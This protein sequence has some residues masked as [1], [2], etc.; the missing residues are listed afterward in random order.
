MSPEPYYVPPLTTTDDT[1]Q[2][3]HTEHTEHTE[4]PDN[5]ARHHELPLF[6]RVRPPLEQ[7]E[8]EPPLILLLH[9]VGSNEED[10]FPVAARMSPNAVVASLRGPLV[11]G[12]HAYAW[13]TVRFT[14]T[15]AEIDAE[16]LEASR[17]RVAE[18]VRAAV[19]RYAA[20]P[21]RVYLVGF[22]Q[23][24]IMSLTLG[25]TEPALVA[26]VVA[27]A[28]RIP[29]EVL[30]GLAGPNA[31]AG[32]PV[33]VAHGQRD[34]II[35]VEEGRK[36]RRILQE[37]RVALAYTEYPGVG[38]NLPPEAWNAALGWLSRQIAAPA[39]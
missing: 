8:G 2:M 25:L 16:E 31:T 13:F 14:P 20:D 15:G 11:R 30:P 27:M 6:A 28:G 22:S 34:E 24:A 17:A 36:A 26:G 3:D 33:Y 35:G 7:S 18:F 4:Q 9:G 29:A 12:H 32:L 23:G 19:E 5:A 21:E 38:H 1:N 39:S 10:L 37:Q